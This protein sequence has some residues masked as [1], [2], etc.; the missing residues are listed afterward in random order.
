ML[1]GWCSV[2]WFALTLPELVNDQTHHQSGS[3]VQNSVVGLPRQIYYQSA[4]QSGE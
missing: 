1:L 3:L 4:L 2:A